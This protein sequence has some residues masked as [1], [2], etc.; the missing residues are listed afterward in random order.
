MTAFAPVLA[1]PR[2]VQP[3]GGDIAG[4]ALGTGAT[5][6]AALPT[7]EAGAMATVADGQGLVS[8]QMG[9]GA[10][11]DVAEAAALPPPQQVVG[12]QAKF[13]AALAA[14]KQPPQANHKYLLVISA[15]LKTAR[16]GR[17]T[18]Q[19]QN[20]TLTVVNLTPPDGLEI[21]AI[22]GAIGA[23]QPGNVAEFALVV[24]DH[25]LLPLWQAHQGASPDKPK[26]RREFMALQ[27]SLMASLDV[28]RTVPGAPTVAVYV[29]DEISSRV[30]PVSKELT[31][32]MRRNV[33]KM[34]NVFVLDQYNGSPLTVVTTASRENWKLNPLDFRPY[35]VATTFPFGWT[36]V[37]AGIL[38]Q[39]ILMG[40]IGHAEERRQAAMLQRAFQVAPTVT[41]VTE[42]LSPYARRALLHKY[43]LMMDP[44]SV[45]AHT[46]T[47]V[48]SMRAANAYIASLSP[49]VASKLDQRSVT[50]KSASAGGQRSEC[51]LLALL[52]TC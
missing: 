25:E 48:P 31:E 16:F 14:L 52:S 2:Q 23:A 35:S 41:A 27:T 10:G 4:P 11:P 47:T 13:H 22:V 5:A 33:A 32:A 18:S 12:P 3:G 45:R 8:M 15:H 44:N 37:G 21:G 9:Q 42:G 1:P 40:A 6:A 50:E 38:C 51:S 24:D 46:E 39:A 7:P 28:L 26:Y 34:P 20:G 43:S 36:V 49:S 30:Q 29:M 19:I 17:S